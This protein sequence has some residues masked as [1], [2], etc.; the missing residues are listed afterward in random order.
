M[1][2]IAISTNEIFIYNIEASKLEHTITQKEEIS[3]VTFLRKQILSIALDRQ[4]ILVNLFNNTYINT[5]EVSDAIIELIAFGDCLLIQSEM[6]F[7]VWHSLTN[8]VQ[9]IHTNKNCIIRKI[10]SN[11]FVCQNY[12]GNI[13]IWKAFPLK[14]IETFLIDCDDPMCVLGTKI[15]F[16]GYRSTTLY[17]LNGDFVENLNTSNTIVS[18]K[19]VKN[20]MIINV[21]GNGTSPF[22]WNLT[23]KE[24]VNLPI[25]DVYSLQCCYDSLVLFCIEN[26][27]YFCNLE[28]NKLQSIQLEKNSFRFQIEEI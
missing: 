21:L 4:V 1:H 9:T 19:P 27:A 17:D 14:K 5:L 23:T 7:C 26:T 15:A 18:A 20:G 25:G 24:Y 2:L 3:C 8:A 13:T 28:T 22:F 10:D 6:L 11:R 16:I 12:R